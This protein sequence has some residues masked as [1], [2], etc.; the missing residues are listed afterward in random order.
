MWNVFEMSNLT[1]V[2]LNTNFYVN[3]RL[4]RKLAVELVSVMVVV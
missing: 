2:L 1:A 4:I 3:L